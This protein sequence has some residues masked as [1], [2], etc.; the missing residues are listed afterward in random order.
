MEGVAGKEGQIDPEDFGGRLV[1]FWSHR[2]LL[3]RYVA[4]CPSGGTARNSYD[5]LF[6]FV[7]V[8][9]KSC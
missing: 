6:P 5:R 1:R 8:R 4:A 3:A 9:K 7:P 2:A